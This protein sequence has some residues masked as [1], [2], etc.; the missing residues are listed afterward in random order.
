MIGLLIEKRAEG[1]GV[2]AGEDGGAN[3]RRQGGEFGERDAA[4]I[5]AAVD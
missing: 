3:G 2:G 4:F 1:V 5:G